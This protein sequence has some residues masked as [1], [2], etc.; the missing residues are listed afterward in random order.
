M[1]IGSYFTSEYSLESAALFNP[2]IIPHPDQTNV[3]AGS[4]R[5]ILSLRATGEGHISC[6]TFRSGVVD[7]NGEI[8]LASGSRF[9]TEPRPI[10][11]A[12][13]ER[14]LFLRKLGELGLDTDFARQVLDALGDKFTFDH[15][16]LSDEQRRNISMGY[17]EAGHMMY[18]H[19]PSLEK[20]KADLAE[21]VQGTTPSR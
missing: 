2:S 13:Y 8:Q 11:S 1:L 20:L 5:V 17:Y 10:P 7:E 14:D 4:I 19:A 21:F 18:V 9:V 6:I 16:H 12:V 15:L 3:A